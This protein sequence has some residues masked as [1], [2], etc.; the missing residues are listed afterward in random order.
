MT[1]ANPSM[2]SQIILPRPDDDREREVFA[3]IADRDKEIAERIEEID[4]AAKT[5]DL[6]IGALQRAF[7]MAATTSTAAIGTGGAHADVP[8]NTEFKKDEGFSHSAGSSEIYL[9]RDGLYLIHVDATAVLTGAARCMSSWRLR[10]NTGGGYAPLADTRSYGYH[11]TTGVGTNTVPM[12]CL[13]VGSAGDKLK[14]QVTSS[15]AGLNLSSG[16]TRILI[17]RAGT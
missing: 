14:L 15:G 9:D 10:V 11:G 8:W 4:D 7:F 1:T 2:S 16:T 3:A 17:E 6:A 12:T 5:L 13:Y